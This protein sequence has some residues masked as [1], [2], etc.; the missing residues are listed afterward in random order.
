[1]KPLAVQLLR[2]LSH[3]HFTSGVTL[4]QKHA[5]SRS[6]ISEAL[7]EATILG[8]EIFSLTRK[9]YRLAQPLDLLDVDAI[10]VQCARHVPGLN[11]EVVFSLPSTNTELIHRA[12][13]GA[14][15]G[16]ILAAEMQTAGRGRRGRVWYSHLGDSL[17]FSLLW[18]F[19]RG[20]AQL[21]GLSLVAGLAVADALRHLGLAAAMVKWP[22]DIWVDGK[23]V[24]G[25]LIETQGDMLGPTAA[26]IGIG[27]NLRLTTPMQEAI[28]QAVTDIA[29]H[30]DVT[31][32]RNA[33]LVACVVELV[34]AITRF[35]TEGFTPFRKHW[36]ACHALQDQSVRVLEGNGTSFDARV[37]DVGPDGAL[38]VKRDGAVLDLNSAE[39]SLRASTAG[40]ALPTRGG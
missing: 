29:S 8:I 30:L 28:D 36:L 18:R 7:K 10:R 37:T 6:A 5:V 33:L 25:V 32:S 35:N 3:E 26:V 38:R 16:T 1:M 21:A 31:P 34:R 23:K 24:G 17:T 20:A 39:V 14:A 27:L 4:A 13:A 15:S 19:E 11:I 2:D 40:A 22:N 9:G 12:A